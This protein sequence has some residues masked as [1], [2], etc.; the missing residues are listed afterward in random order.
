M[1]E[2]IARVV[3]TAAFL[4]FVTVPVGRAQTTA[5]I[6]GTVMDPSGAVVPDAK[7]TLTEQSMAVERSATTGPSGDY[8]FPQVLPGTYSLSVESS[9]FRK[10]LQSG[11]ALVINQAARVDV[12]LTVGAPNQMIEVS[13][14][15]PLVTTVNAE[16]GSVEN[17]QRIVDL[18]LVERDT[19][20]LGLL[21]AGV[22]PADPNDGSGNP[23]SVSGQRSESLTFL[24]DGADNNDF[25]GNNIVVNANPDAIREFKILTNNYSAEFGRTSG[26]IVN[27]VT[28]SGT[29]AFHGD[30][31]EF[32]RNDV[33]NARD[34]FLPDRT[35]F[36]RNLFGGTIGGPIK[37]DKTFFFGS[38]Q[39]GRRREGQVAPV[40]Q[41]L[42]PAER[43]GNFSELC[44]TYDAGGLCTDPSGTQLFNP[45]SGN[46]YVNNQVPV[47]PIIANY[48]DRFLPLPNLPGNRFVSGPVGQFRDDQGVVHLD[49]IFSERDMLTGVY[50]I[51]DNDD[52]FPFQIINGASTGGN[53]PVGSGFTDTQRSQVGTI[54][55]T[56]TF[57][58]NMINVAR[59]SAN[60]V[61]TLQASP[62]DTTTPA[63][64]GF[65]NVNPDDA[66]GSAAPILFT[67]SFNLGPSPQGPTNLVRNSFQWQ[68]TLTVVHGNH[69]L[70]FGGDIRRI[71]NNF[72]FDFFNNG[73]F[74]F[75]AFGSFTEDPLADFVGGFPDNFFQFSTATYGIRTTSFYFF[76]QD[77]W[78]VTPKLTLNFGL[79]YE[80]NTPQRD[81]HNNVLGFF[82][83]KQSTVFPDA[84]PGILYPGDPGTPNRALVF[85]DKNNFAPR[86]GFAYNVL[87]NSK[88]VVRGGF[89]IFYDL[90]DGA[91]NLQ[92]GGQPP[93]GDVINQNF[94][95]PDAFAGAVG[96]DPVSDP[97]GAAGITNPFPFASAGRVGQFF[98]PKI[99]FAFVVDPRFR[100]PYS[101]NYNLGLQY[102][103]TSNTLLEAYYVGSLGRKLISTAEVNFP[104][105]EIEK[106][107]L[108]AFGGVNPDCA[109]PLAGCSDPLDPDA[110]P[111][112]SVFLIS[113]HSN[114]ISDSHQ[115]QVTL[116][117][118]MSRGFTF[119]TAYT[120][121]KTIDI[122]SG[123]RSRSSTFTNPLD[124]NFDR[125]VADFDV[126]HRLVMSGI[127]QL[128]YQRGAG[129]NPIV[130]KLT[131]GW[132]VNSI[133]TFQSGFPFTLFQNN[134][135]SLQGNFLDRPDQ[136][137]AVQIFHDP[138]D[139]RTF[140]PNADGTHGSCLGDTA[141]GNFY[142]DPTNLD[143]AT[144]P[145]FTF[146]SLG[147]NALR[148]PGISN[149]D[150]SIFK[151]TYITESKYVQ[152]HAE[153]FNAFNHTQFLN[154]DP[155]GFANTFGQ[156]TSA[157]DP[158]LIQFALKLYF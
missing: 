38:Y 143:C 94:F 56:H 40:L 42:S 145:A 115:L 132:Q 76:S 120:Y 54:S 126:T 136:V 135:S 149:V 7:V 35:S 125:G 110:F 5:S 148:G 99:S 53:V 123:F 17:S 67:P 50:L 18:P 101:Q 60:R 66:A 58:P 59:I 61:A 16:L 55:W 47:N 52:F 51:N 29:N 82:P 37:K 133:V 21:Q 26:G 98:D 23:F 141:T 3:F 12:T 122:T 93:F 25:L 158:R 129:N 84:P 79:R 134:D 72:V 30:I 80:Y 62:V 105:P 68:D 85:P 124:F 103:L 14:G 44:G 45:V 100:T 156:I 109:R 112:D 106:Q 113:N 64:L 24:V 34:Y 65:T 4:L 75:G 31:F 57:G 152:F 48:I 86:F 140:S 151:N 74:D 36:K 102:Q 13:E 41:V 43:S 69:E 8:I 78:K 81:P 49:H 10:Y 88:L 83:G 11:I 116:D 96:V 150:F 73:S 39:G 117:K 71:Q 138:R 95:P 114:G 118:R 127:W 15:A 89:G 28:K 19:L 155:N 130:R 144:V 46:P 22:T 1:K 32:F 121:A 107:Q 33:L 154:P 87:G 147:R 111:T 77:N 90:E 6:R 91:L 63:E 128:P 131:E 139:V 157:R 27:Q 137:G 104:N 70:K 97:F 146:G 9:G 153:F 108:A 92:F 119:R 2:F 20:L 142:L